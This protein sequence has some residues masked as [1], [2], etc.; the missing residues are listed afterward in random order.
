MTSQAD[1]SFHPSSKIGQSDSTP[2]N[3]PANATADDDDADAPNDDD[4][5]L[6]AEGTE[7][8]G[9]IFASGSGGAGAA[10]AGGED[11]GEVLGKESWVG[12]TRDYTYPEVSAAS[13]SIERRQI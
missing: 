6:G 3:L 1:L 12:S 5:P 7:E 8:I 2:T 13:R 9:D 4:A 10:G 11:G